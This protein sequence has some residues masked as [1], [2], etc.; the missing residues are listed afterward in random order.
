MN[1]MRRQAASDGLLA[2]VALWARGVAMAFAPIVML[3]S[4]IAATAIAGDQPLS[5]EKAYRYAARVEGDRLI[6][7]WTVEPGYYLYKKKMSMA[8]TVS[9]VQVNEPS[10]LVRSFA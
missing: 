7:K 1:H 2:K 8:S 5:A 6:V 10:W 3:S 9:T 4:V